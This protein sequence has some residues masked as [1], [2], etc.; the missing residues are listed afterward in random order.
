[1]N[2]D[3]II[4]CILKVTA[5][6]NLNIENDLNQPESTKSLEQLINEQKKEENTE[7]NTE[8]N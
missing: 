5:S 4:P 8:K 7:E 3:N 1:M 2:T 6:Y